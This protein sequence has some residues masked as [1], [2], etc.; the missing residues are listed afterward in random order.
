MLLTNVS[1]DLMPMT[2]E[3]GDTSNLAATR[4][5]SAL[6][7]AEAPARIW[8][9]LNCFWVAKIRGAMLS[10]TKPLN[11][12]LSATRIF[13]KP[14]LFARASAAFKKKLQKLKAIK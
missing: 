1:G 9:K 5:S 12:S 13:A 10:A 8:V 11:A 2:S 3:I 6:P 14:L 4:G 7:K